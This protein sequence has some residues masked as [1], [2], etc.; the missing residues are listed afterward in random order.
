MGFSVLAVLSRKTAYHMAPD[1][2]DD[3]VVRFNPWFA[4]S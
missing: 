1:V 3:L 4:A 2:V